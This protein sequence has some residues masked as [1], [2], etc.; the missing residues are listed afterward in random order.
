MG[1]PTL[2]YHLQAIED[3]HRW[4]TSVVGGLTAVGRAA[5]VVSSAV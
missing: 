1:C 3:L 4:F 5:V 2:M